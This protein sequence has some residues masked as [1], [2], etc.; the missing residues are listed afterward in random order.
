MMRRTAT[1]GEVAT[2]MRELATLRPDRRGPVVAMFSEVVADCS[3]CDDPVRRC[4]SR[5]LVRR[6]LVH[7]RCAPPQHLS[8]GQRDALR[9][10]RARGSA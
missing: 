7:L 8:D 10:M 5:G 2:W 6:R 3:Y 4:D 1:P 9:H